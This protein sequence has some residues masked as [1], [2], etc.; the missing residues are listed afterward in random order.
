VRGGLGGWHGRALQAGDTLPLNRSAATRAERRLPHAPKLAA[1]SVLRVQP[2]P[3]LDRFAP[4]ALHAFLD[5]DYTVTPA[6][7]RSGLRLE[8][9]KLDHAGEYD[10]LSEGVVSGSIQVPGSGQPVLLV[11]DHPTVGGYPRLATVISADL[12][13]AGRLRIGG[14]VRFVAVDAAEATRARVDADERYAATAAS[15]ERVN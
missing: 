15:I 3:H 9:A 2:G 13:A 14:R 5:G 12:A 10:L 11:A 8:G 1:P 7:D 4:H 6:S